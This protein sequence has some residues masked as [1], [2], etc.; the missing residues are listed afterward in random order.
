MKFLFKS[1]RKS[2]AQIVTIA[3]HRPLNCRMTTSMSHHNDVLIMSQKRM[4]DSNKARPFNLN[5]F[6]ICLPSGF[7]HRFAAEKNDIKIK[8]LSKVLHLPDDGGRLSDSGISVIMSFFHEIW[9]MNQYWFWPRYWWRMKWVFWWLESIHSEWWEN[10]VSE[11]FKNF[12]VF[13]WRWNEEI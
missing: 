4:P 8:N 5:R 13:S 9:P 7:L 11:K 3:F 2:S 12:R 6:S 1:R 10:E